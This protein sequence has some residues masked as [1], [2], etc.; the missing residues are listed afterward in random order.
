MWLGDFPEDFTAVPCLF[1]THDRTSAP[2]APSS[3]LEAADVAIFKNGSATEKTSTNGLT[4][5]SPFNGTTGLHCLTIDTSNDTGD[6]GFW[7]AGAVYTIALVPDET[8]DG[9]AVVNV[10]GQFGISLVAPNI[11]KT[12]KAVARGTVTTGGSTTS[13]PVSAFTIAG[14]AASGVVA[15]QFANRVVLFDGNTTTAG[16]RGAV[17]TISASTA[18]DTPTLS[19]STLPATPASGDT[20]SII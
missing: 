15:N 8:V 5:T 11:D 17:A 16:L 13:V 6:A 10:I 12:I 3:A 7:V 1:T 14:S 20:F 4:M 9:V 18:S 2:V 19:V